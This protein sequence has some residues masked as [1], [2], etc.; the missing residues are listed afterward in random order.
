MFFIYVAERLSWKEALMKNFG[1]K[2]WTIEANITT[3]WVPWNSS[4]FNMRYLNV[5]NIH[6]FLSFFFSLIST[7]IIK[8]VVTMQVKPLTKPYTKI[9]NKA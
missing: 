1:P 9:S 8:W 2:G 3:T 5:G 7:K 4:S 6:L